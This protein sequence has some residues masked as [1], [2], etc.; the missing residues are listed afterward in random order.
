MEDA[1]VLYPSPAI[2]HLISM[3]ELGRLVLKHHPSFSI[4]IL[5]TNP[6]YNTGSTAPYISRVSATTPAIKFYHLPT[7]SVSVH[8]S[9][10]HPETLAFEFLR[11][12]NP[13]LHQALLTISQTS[14]VRALIID[15]F[16]ITALT[17]A[18]ELKI[19][20][21]CFFTSGAC[22]LASFLYL[23]TIH[24]NT[25]KSLKDLDTHLDIPGLPPFPGTDMP[26]PMLDRTDKAYECF[27]DVCA[28]LPKLAG[29]IVNTFEL[30]ESR[31][32]EA[33]RDGLCVPDEPTP[34]LFCIGPLIAADDR[35]G[36]GGMHECLVWLDSQPS[37]SVVFL[38]FGSLGLF[39]AEQLKEIAVGLE[40]S[41]QKFLWVVRSP[42]TEDQT[43]HFLPPAEPD[44]DSL[45]PEGFLDRTKERGLVIKSWAPQVA[46]LNHDSVGGFVTHCGWNSVLE[47]MCA[48]VPMIAWPLYAEQRFNRVIL[49]EEM[50]LA[51]AME[52]SEDGFVSSAEVEKRVRELMESEEGDSVRKKTQVTKEAMET[53]I[54]VDSGSSRL[55]LTKLAESWTRG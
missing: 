41:G 2:G 29:I 46:V 21:Y 9:S 32:L 3:V 25:T 4:T 42:P 44:L 55:A 34:P 51:L 31:A 39:S 26:K 33:I 37:R 24:R 23:P 53:A 36:G 7:I 28:N 22:C 18:A 19:P 54:T 13:L 15:F 14:N 45:L 5:I 48:G 43:K 12:N 40:R 10:P 6:P 17:V 47:A 49:V 20:V 8:P 35:T 11:L 50:K 52:E 38:C 1:I 16:C 30:L 27:L